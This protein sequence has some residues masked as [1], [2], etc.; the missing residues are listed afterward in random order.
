MVVLQPIAL[1]SEFLAFCVILPQNLHFLLNDLQNAKTPKL[2]K[3]SENNKAKGL[4]N[5]N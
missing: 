3:K 4:N 2:A 1:K 5:V